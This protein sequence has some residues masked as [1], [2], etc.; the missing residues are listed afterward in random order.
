MDHM[1]K[2]LQI[3]RNNL[4]QLKKFF[5]IQKNV[6]NNFFCFVSVPILNNTNVL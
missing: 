4:R 3:F 2:F 6:S 5:K 1:T